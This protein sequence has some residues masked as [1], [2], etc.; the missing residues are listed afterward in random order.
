MLGR[1]LGWFL[2]VVVI[3]TIVMVV[4][5]AVVVVAVAVAVVPVVAK[6]MIVT[7]LTIWSHAWGDM[8][9]DREVAGYEGVGYHT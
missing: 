9:L 2:A 7:I 3:L 6:S 5:V 1:Y 8:R 4:A